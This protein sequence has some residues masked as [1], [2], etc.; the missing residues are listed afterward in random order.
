ML[1][2]DGDNKLIIGNDYTLNDK[3]V[4]SVWTTVALTGKDMLHKHADRLK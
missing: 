1:D 4:I 3:N 2:N